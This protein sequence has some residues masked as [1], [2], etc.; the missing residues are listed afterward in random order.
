MSVKDLRKKAEQLQPQLEEHSKYVLHV[1]SKDQLLQH[2][3]Q[4]RR[5]NCK[6]RPWWEPTGLD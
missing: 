3:H 6:G 4:Q 2:H 5:E 1:M